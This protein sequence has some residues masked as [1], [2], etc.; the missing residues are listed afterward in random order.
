[1]RQRPHPVDVE[2]VIAS[3][4]DRGMSHRTIVYT[5]GAIRQVLAYGMTEGLIAI[6]VNGQ[7]QGSP[8]ATQRLQGARDRLGA[9]GVDQV[10]GCC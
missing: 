9:R 3:L 2:R 5:L 4:R 10:P 8:E 6:N 7:R 1:M